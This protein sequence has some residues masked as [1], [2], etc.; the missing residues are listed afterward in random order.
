MMVPVIALGI[1]FV[2]GHVHGHAV[3][4]RQ[5]HAKGLGQRRPLAGI[6]FGG[7]GDDPLPSRPSVLAVLGGFGSVPDRTTVSRPAIG[8]D[9]LG[10]H[11][12]AAPGVVV[13]HAGAFI[14]QFHTGPIGRRSNSRPPATAGDWLGAGVEDGDGSCSCS[15]SPR[16]AR[17]DLP[18]ASRKCA[19]RCSLVACLR[20]I[21]HH[22]PAP[23]RHPWHRRWN[24]RL[25]KQ[26]PS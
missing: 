13:D 18:Q 3:P 21:L 23:E 20:A 25:P 12:T 2:D 22:H 26:K 16:R 19:L 17:R 6:Q 4:T 7:Q 1:G 14:D 11:D 9:D 10:G 15:G 5:F 24:R 8:K